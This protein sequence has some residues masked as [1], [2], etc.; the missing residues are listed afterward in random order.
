MGAMPN[1]RIGCEFDKFLHATIGDD[2]GMPLTVLSALARLNV[3]PW[4]EA[5][6]LTRLTEQCAVARLAALLGALRHGPLLCPDPAGIAAPL[7]ALL[8]PNRDYSSPVLRTL[9][10][11]APKKHPVA[12]GDLFAVHAVEQLAVGQHAD[13]APGGSLRGLGRRP[14]FGPRRDRSPV[15]FR[16]G[17]HRPPTG[18]AAA[19]VIAVHVKL[20]RL[21]EIDARVNEAKVNND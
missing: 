2:D 3:D 7:I 15:A 11:V 1:T 5:A 17:A 13:P 18:H 4:E 10:R 19:V 20:R 14:G 21:R 8:P 12:G 16:A 9:A 6:K